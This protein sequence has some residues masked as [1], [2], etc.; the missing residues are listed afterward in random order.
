MFSCDNFESYGQRFQ[1]LIEQKKERLIPVE[2]IAQKLRAEAISINT[3]VERDIL[4]ITTT[5]I[6]TLESE[7]GRLNGVVDKYKKERQFGFIKRILV[8][9]LASALTDT[10]TFFKSFLKSN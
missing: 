1:W 10:S 2:V 7:A 5:L 3:N 9:F 6:H 4:K 8:L